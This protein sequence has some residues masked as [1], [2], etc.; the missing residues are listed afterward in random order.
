MLRLDRDAVICDLAETYGIFNYQALPVKLLAT[1]VVGLREDSR[2]MRKIS[3]VKISRGEMLLAA[4]VDRLSTITWMLSDSGTNGA[5]R[6]RSVLDA[7]LGVPVQ[8]PPSDVEAYDTPEDYEEE[9][10]RRTGVRHGQ[11]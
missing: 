6:P 1:L 11:E 5:N 10:F 4:V 8:M 7:L 9:W 3:G 2:I